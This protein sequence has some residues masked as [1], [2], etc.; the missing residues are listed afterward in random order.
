MPTTFHLAGLEPGGARELGLLP[1][2]PFVVGANDGVLSNLGVNAIG[3]GEVAVTIGTSGAMRTVVDRPLT[4]PSG[5]TF[6]YAL[7]DRHWVIGGPVNNGGIV[8]RWVRDELAAA[9]CET[10]RRLAIDPYD[11][12][13]R[14]AERVAPG[15]AGLL[16]HPYLSGERSP[17]W[18]ANLRGSF[19]GLAT[20]HRRAVSS[21]PL[22]VHKRQVGCNAT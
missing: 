18:D 8:F 15:A 20:H 22:G 13:T 10:A 11:V 6:C 16:F 14:I 17:R 4:D 21:T 3:P 9:E 5:R 7:T 1:T 19:F 2:T 12:L